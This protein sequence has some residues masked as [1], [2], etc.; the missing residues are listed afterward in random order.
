[1]GYDVT[2]IKHRKMNNFKMLTNA[3]EILE[4][5]EAI[6]KFNQLKNFYRNGHLQAV[7]ADWGV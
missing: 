3:K 7:S 6:E 2:Q 1:M 4:M 5:R